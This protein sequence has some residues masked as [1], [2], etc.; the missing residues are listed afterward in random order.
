MGIKS[1]CLQQRIFTGNPSKMKLVILLTISFFTFTESYV[2]GGHFANKTEVPLQCGWQMTVGGH[3]NPKRGDPRE[4][5]FLLITV[6]EG[7]SMFMVERKP[8]NADPAANSP[9]AVELMFQDGKLIKF[10]VLVKSNGTFVSILTPD[11]QEL[12]PVEYFELIITFTEE[13]IVGTFNGRTFRIPRKYAPVGL[14]HITGF[15]EVVDEP[16]GF[17]FVKVFRCKTL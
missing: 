5:R 9:F 13:V 17:T 6:R 4:I 15:P 1:A 12:N 7:F 11:M 16:F 3:I 8:S 2:F 10:S 14:V